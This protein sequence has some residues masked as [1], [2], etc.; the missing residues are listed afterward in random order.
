MS[1]NDDLDY[2][3]LNLEG[4][5]D[6]PFQIGSNQFYSDQQLEVFLYNANQQAKNIDAWFD[7]PGVYAKVGLASGGDGLNEQDPSYSLTLTCNACDVEV[8]S[9]SNCSG[10]TLN[11]YDECGNIIESEDCG[12]VVCWNDDRCCDDTDHYLCAYSADYGWE[13]VYNNQCEGIEQGLYEICG[14][15]CGT[16]ADGE[17]VC[18]PPT[19]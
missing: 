7:P 10:N 16:N 15:S 12:D 18:D 1:G 2:Y 6:G 4:Q 14:D 8:E 13:I 11:T 5:G 3:Y 17:V 19:N 9:S